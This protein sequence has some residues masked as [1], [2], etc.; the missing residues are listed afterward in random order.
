MPQYSINQTLPEDQHGATLYKDE[1]TLVRQH[2]NTH[3][4]SDSNLIKNIHLEATALMEGRAYLPQVT[5][6]NRETPDGD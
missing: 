3:N 6:S 5:V 1:A 2:G 4:K